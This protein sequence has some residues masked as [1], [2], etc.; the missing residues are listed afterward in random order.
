MMIDPTSQGWEELSEIRLVKPSA[1]CQVQDLKAHQHLLSKSHPWWL[2]SNE[3]HQ[4]MYLLHVCA[5]FW[6]YCSSLLVM[7][8]PKDCVTCNWWTGF[9]SSLYKLALKS[10]SFPEG[11]LQL[12]CFS[13]LHPFN[14]P[15]SLNQAC[16]RHRDER[17]SSSHTELMV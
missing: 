16:T 9:W 15:L 7:H 4:F 1:Q 11:L 10:D 5:W 2:K 8:Y 14:K 13:F 12:S 17:T 3:N 6:L